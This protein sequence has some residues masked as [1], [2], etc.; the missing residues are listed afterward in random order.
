[1][2]HE[3]TTRRV[4]W[5][6]FLA[7]VMA[8]APIHLA[9]AQNGQRSKLDS[10]L[11]NWRGMSICQ[12]RPSGC[13]DEDSLYHVKQ[14]ATAPDTFELQA[15]KIVNGKTVTMGTSS[16]SY[17]AAGQLVCPIPASGATSTFEVH[18]DDM[19]GTMKLQDGTVWRKLAL[20]RVRN[21]A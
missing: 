19:K 16:C 17:G 10:P 3:F 1:M 20:K 14:L 12:V 4:F 5:L 13:H 6:F 9:R 21:P 15:D 7:I 11:G 2:L 18:G 8:M